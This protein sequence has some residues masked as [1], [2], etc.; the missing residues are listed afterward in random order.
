MESREVWVN[1]SP[2]LDSKSYGHYLPFHE[3]L[4]DAVL[5]HGLTYLE[6][7]NRSKCICGKYDW[8]ANT[9]IK[10]PGYFK[11]KQLLV[12]FH[13]LNE[14]KSYKINLLIYEGS[15]LTFKM[16]SI[17]CYF[18]PNLRV[19]HNWSNDKQI[20]KMYN[21]HRN[22]LKH[23]LKILKRYSSN[24]IISTVENLNLSLKLSKLNG[25]KFEVFPTSSVFKSSET[26]DLGKDKL[27]SILIFLNDS[28]REKTLI[29]EILNESKVLDNSTQI[30]VFGCSYLP[31]HNNTNVVF[32][33]K[34]Q[35]AGDRYEQYFMKCKFAIFFYSQKNYESLTSG[36]FMD[37][38]VARK[39]IWLEKEF[40]A[41]DWLAEQYPSNCHRFSTQE[42]RWLHGI[43]VERNG[44]YNLDSTNIPIARNSVSILSKYLLSDCN[45][46]KVR[47]LALFIY[48]LDYA[49]II[50][51]YLLFL[52]REL[53]KNL[54]FFWSWRKNNVE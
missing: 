19:V 20:T 52:I 10:G 27:D 7:P 8:D 9:I 42:A 54:F 49:Y 17:L 37:C 3:T 32:L 40:T 53:F 16:V 15:F 1:F 18:S 43:S 38:I 22:Y 13:I 41:L 46:G 6:L 36:R 5:S 29:Q 28:A 33:P 24:Q 23:R 2:K 39:N 4:K 51:R 34:T 48:F 12:L 25:L 21:K 47:N 31:V 45:P 44:F 30:I 14:L 50:I 11:L 35:M 26:F